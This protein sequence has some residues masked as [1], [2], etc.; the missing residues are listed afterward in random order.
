MHCMHMIVRI[1][2]KR[3]YNILE[4]ERIENKIQKKDMK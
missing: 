4:K 1:D 2:G 3:E